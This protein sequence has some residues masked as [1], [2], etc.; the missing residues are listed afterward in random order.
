[1]EHTL[2][3]HTHTHTNK[4]N[5]GERLQCAMQ[6]AREA[7]A[8]NELF[9]DVACQVCDSRQDEE[10]MVLCDMC[11]AGMYVYTQRHTEI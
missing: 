3:I 4:Q 5:L 2:F 9:V 11:D 10:S 7:R 6:L 8:E 1:M